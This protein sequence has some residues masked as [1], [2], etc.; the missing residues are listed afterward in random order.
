MNMLMESG[1]TGTNNTFNDDFLFDTT[2]G[3][4]S[5]ANSFIK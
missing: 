5:F 4:E 3:L 2:G 1:I